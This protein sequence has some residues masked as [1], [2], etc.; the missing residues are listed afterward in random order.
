[1]PRSIFI[2]AFLSL[3]MAVGLFQLKYKVADQERQ[4]AQLSKDIYQTEE[5]IH[6]LQ[7]E[8]SYLND[9][10]RLQRLA[11]KHLRLE[12]AETI[13]L[14]KYEQMDQLYKDKKGTAAEQLVQA[15]FRPGY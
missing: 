10:Q 11:K 6:I 14:V 15:R 3:C 12:Q 9:P 13:Q 7:A 4:L 8:W 2:G 1:M 5:A